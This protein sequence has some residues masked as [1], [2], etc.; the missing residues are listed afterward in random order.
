M[1]SFV[2]VVHLSLTSLSDSP[3]DKKLALYDFL[4]NQNEKESSKIVADDYFFP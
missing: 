2:V 3:H 4:L 1:G